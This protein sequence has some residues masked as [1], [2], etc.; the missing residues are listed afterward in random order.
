[1]NISVAFVLRFSSEVF[2]KWTNVFKGSSYCRGRME[3]AYV[4]K[5]FREY[6]KNKTKKILEF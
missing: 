4:R 5:M 6:K 3:C 2:A 1:M